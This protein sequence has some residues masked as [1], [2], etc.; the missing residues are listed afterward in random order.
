MDPKQRAAEA[1]LD[2]LGNDLVVGL[3]SGSTSDCFHVA[4]ARALKD[5]RFRNIVGVPTSKRAEQHAIELG[6]P[7]TT[8]TRAPNPDITVDGADEVAPNLDVIK[9]LGGALLREKIVAQASK[10][11]VIIGDSSKTVSMLGTKQPLPVEVAVFEHET[12]VP[13]FR[14]LGCEP[15]LRRNA[16]GTPYA[17]DNSNY[18]YHCRFERIDDPPALQRALKSRAGIVETGLFIGMAHIALIATSTDVRKMTR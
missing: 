6:I 15:V 4:L 13:F 10:K 7:L 11:L 16:N 2:L 18:I 8:L 1:A 17:T 9:G 12:H 14:S 3:G 5:G